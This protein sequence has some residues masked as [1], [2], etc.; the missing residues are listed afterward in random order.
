[1]LDPACN[2]MLSLYN[3]RVI[4]I[5]AKYLSTGVLWDVI[6]A[7]LWEWSLVIGMILFGVIMFIETDSRT[8]N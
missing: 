1:M 7:S 5:G 6:S 2:Q 4:T 3:N 8:S